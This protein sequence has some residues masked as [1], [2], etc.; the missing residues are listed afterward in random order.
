MVQ[1]LCLN[2][3]HPRKLFQCGLNQ[4][5]VFSK[6]VSELQRLLLLLGLL[7]LRHAPPHVPLNMLPLER[8]QTSLKTISATKRNKSF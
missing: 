4:L 5:C 3:M 8:F 2:T 1:L 6:Y 7:G